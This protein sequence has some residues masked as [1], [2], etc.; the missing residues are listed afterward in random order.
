MMRCSTHASIRQATSW[1]RQVLMVW[2]ESTMCSLVLA[3]LSYKVTKTKS[4]KSHSTHRATRSSQRAAT[5]R[6]DFGQLRLVMRFSAWE[7]TRARDTRMK[8]SLARSTMRVTRSLQ[9][10][11][12]TPAASGRIRD[13]SGPGKKK[14]QSRK[15]QPRLQ[16]WVGKCRHQLKH[17]RNR[18]ERRRAAN[19]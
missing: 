1:L 9:V 12:I 7:R 3:R 13:S 10:L 6:A 5:R 18:I 8:F 16:L 4:V 11:K 19:R 2:P 15:L 17:N 14:M